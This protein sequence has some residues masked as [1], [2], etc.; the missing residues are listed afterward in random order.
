MVEEQLGKVGLYQENVLES[1]DLAA[2]DGS[3]KLYSKD[4]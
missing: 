2:R 4:P 3:Q 1:E